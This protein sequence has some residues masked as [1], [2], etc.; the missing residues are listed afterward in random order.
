MHVEAV[1]FLERCAT[2]GEL[3]FLTWPTVMGYLRIATHPAVFERPLPPADA[4]ENF[5]RLLELPHV[6]VLGEGPRFWPHYKRLTQV[7]VV[8][9]N[10]V[11][12]AHLAALL[13]SHGV[14]T[15]YTRDRDFRKFDGLRVI[16]P[17]GS[18]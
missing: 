2:G 16:D 12:G 8:R 13:Q 1:R 15:L 3:F 9:G 18:A 6:R 4:L 11:P 7:Q 14:K 10:L 17:F 5:D